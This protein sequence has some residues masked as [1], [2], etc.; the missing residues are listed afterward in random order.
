MGFKFSGVDDII[1]GFA[2]KMTKQ[3]YASNDVAAKQITK[4]VGNAVNSNTGVD[5]GL[6]GM[7]KSF[8][9]SLGGHG[10]SA[11]HG[12]MDMVGEQPILKGLMPGSEVK[13]QVRRSLTPEQSGEISSALSK[14]KNSYAAEIKQLEAYQ[15][16]VTGADDW[17]NSDAA[18]KARAGKYDGTETSFDFTGYGNDAETV[19]QNIQKRTTELTSLSDGL[20]EQIDNVGKNF[21]M[22]DQ[23]AMEKTMSYFT[24]SQYGKKRMAAAAIGTAGVAVGG[25]LASGGSLTRDA[26]GR[27]DI[28]GVPLI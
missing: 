9:S 19:L 11:Y 23:N 1:K 28:A 15:N 17:F 26:E 4:Q 10:Q 21:F 16:T 25:R 7:V 24:D 6:L 27:R 13:Q 18:I 14:Q 8:D 5:N 20:D 22:Q 3:L 2:P 12:L